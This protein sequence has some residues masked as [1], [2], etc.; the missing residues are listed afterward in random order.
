MY[1]AN[2]VSNEDLSKMHNNT[3]IQQLTDCDTLLQEVQVLLLTTSENDR[4]AVL[5]YLKPFKNNKL[6]NYTPLSTTSNSICCIIGKYGSSITA[7]MLVDHRSLQTKQLPFSLLS[8]FPNV[9]AVFAV[10]VAYGIMRHVKMWDV[11]LSSNLYTLNAENLQ[12]T[13][14]ELGGNSFQS[15]TSQFLCEHFS[16]PPLWPLKD[17]NIVSRIKDSLT[18]PCLTQGSV[19][20]CCNLSDDLSKLRS[21]SSLSDDIIAIEMDGIASLSDYC[22]RSNIHFMVAMA[23]GSLGDSEYD[24][25]CQPTAASLAADCL[26]HYFSDPQLPHNLAACRG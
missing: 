6:Y 3:D 22:R 9:C 20:S 7:I 24:K 4:L 8:H 13:K 12:E 1:I 21:L 16:Q 5:A 2:L 10:G 18:H 25:V 14:S 19:L 23:I 17:N 15:L 26:H 11:V